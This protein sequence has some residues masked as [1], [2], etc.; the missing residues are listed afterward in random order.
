MKYL[1]RL[2]LF[3][4]GFKITGIDPEIIPKKL[5]AVY[6]HTSNWDF[7]LG[8]LLRRAMPIRVNFIAKSSL[9]KFPFGWIF[10]SLG[11]IP[12]ERSSSHNFVDTMVQ[13][14]NTH[15]RIAFAIA[16]EGT[17]RRVTKF[18]SGFYYIALN[19]H[20]PIIL[21][22]F[23]FGKKVCNFSEPFTPT[24]DY[25]KDM[26]FIIQHFQ[27]AK[28]KNDQDRCRFEDEVIHQ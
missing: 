26:S 11:G 1:S 24:G 19:A 22:T 15:E 17:R 4:W 21:V 16:P 28:G 27:G 12:V 8:L 2:I 3:L 5:Y 14:Y 18:K 10:R 25:K 7:P 13:V 20:I 6:P 9:F 23:D